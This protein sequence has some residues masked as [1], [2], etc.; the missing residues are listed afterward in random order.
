MRPSLYAPLSPLAGT[1]LA[2]SACKPSDTQPAPRSQEANATA[3]TDASAAVNK[4]ATLAIAVS[5]GDDNLKAVLWRQ[6]SEACRAVAEQT[7]RAAFDRFER[8]LVQVTANTPQ[9][10]GAL[11]QQYHDRFGERWWRLPN[12]SDG[13]WELAQFDNDDSQPWQQ[14]HDAKRAALE[15]AR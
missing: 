15:V 1:A 14:R 2:R 13:G 6:R 9:A 12:P 7:Y 8:A 10:D 3:N 11:M 5:A 4:A